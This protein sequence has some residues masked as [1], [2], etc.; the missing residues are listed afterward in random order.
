MNFAKGILETRIQTYRHLKSILKCIP[1][2]TPTIIELSPGNEIC[3]TLFD[4]N[5][6][7]GAVMFLI[8]GNGK[9]ILYT[10]DVRSETWV[11]NSLTQN[12]VLI[13]YCTEIKTLDT[14]YLDTTFAVNQEPYQRFPSKAEGIQ[15]L[16]SKVT[17][18]PNDTKFYFV[19]WTFGYENVWMALSTFLQSKIH[20]DTYRWRLY[21]SLQTS[22]GDLSTRESPY[23]CGYKLGNHDRSGCLTRDPSVR[24]H[25]CEHGGGCAYMDRGGDGEV[26]HIVPILTRYENGV[27]VRELGAGGGKGD[28]DTAQKIEL[29]D[30]PAYEALLELCKFKIQDQTTLQRVVDLIHSSYQSRRGKMKLES[31]LNKAESAEV[32][33]DIDLDRL[34]E[35]LVNMSREGKTI[36]T[37]GFADESDLVDDSLPKTITFPY[38]RHSSYL[39]LCDLV[40]AF[41]PRDVYPCTVDEGNWDPDSS[42]RCLF[43][44]YCSSSIFRHDAEMYKQYRQFVETSQAS[45]TQSTEAI[46][47]NSLEIEEYSHVSTSIRQSEQRTTHGIAVERGTCETH[48]YLVSETT[49]SVR[50]QHTDT[51]KHSLEREISPPPR[52]KKSTREWAYE[53]VLNLNPECQDWDEFGGLSCTQDPKKSFELGSS[54]EEL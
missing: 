3:V 20:L 28:M 5:H 11:I 51:K 16:L 13:P 19:A 35:E 37:Q 18:Y 14:I 49:S 23:L 44:Q 47:P 34:I 15:E 10:G 9:A 39:E 31:H 26:V 4:S 29:Q 8:E 50:L 7:I 22:S 48:T 27:D 42:V 52:K 43:G 12:P 53:A 41:R 24:I 32:D 33:D 36:E 2:D 40:A 17:K 6:C 1:L 45:S 21:Q 54:M 30:E 38:S 46:S 25:S